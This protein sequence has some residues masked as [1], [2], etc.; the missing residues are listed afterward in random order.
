MICFTGEDF[1]PKQVK[2]SQRMIQYFERTTCVLPSFLRRDFALHHLHSGYLKQDPPTFWNPLEKSLRN[3]KVV[4]KE[5]VLITAAFM[6][7][8]LVWTRMIGHRRNNYLMIRFGKRRVFERNLY[9]R[10]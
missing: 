10:R 1:Q 8:C 6:R 9:A 3:Y 4:D 2:W 7:R 5:D